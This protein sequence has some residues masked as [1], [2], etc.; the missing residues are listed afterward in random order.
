MGT[1]FRAYD[2]RLCRE[3]AVKTLHPERVGGADIATLGQSLREA[4]GRFAA[5]ARAMAAVSHPNVVA[6]YDAGVADDVVFLAMELVEGQTLRQWLSTP[7]TWREIVEAFI[8]AAR[9]LAAAHELGLVH[10]D[11][12]PDNVLVGRDGRVRVTDF[13]LVTTE[14]EAASTLTEGPM[15]DESFTQTGMSVGTPAYM[16]PEQ[17]WGGVVD[18]RSD[19][20]AFCVALY[21]ALH[22]ERPFRARC[23]ADLARRKTVGEMSPPRPGHKVPRWLDAIVTRGLSAQADDRFH[24]MNDLARE[25]QS[26]LRR[27]VKARRVMGKVCFVAAL[28]T[29][30][31]TAIFDLS[32]TAHAAAPTSVEGGS[33]DREGGG[34]RWALPSGGRAG[35]ALHQD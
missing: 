31:T 21:E 26:G 17:H 6:V 27:R 16:A 13:G 8:Q 15:H 12:K 32:S 7:R 20:F 34:P 14:G 29:L 28:A 23:C 10:R 18:A 19:Q 3:V 24:A 5:E 4:R 2:P 1:V 30:A 25:L 22:G 11:F 33:P 9:G 35:A